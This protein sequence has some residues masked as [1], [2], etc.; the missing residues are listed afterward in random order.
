MFQDVSLLSSKYSCAGLEMRAARVVVHIVILISKIATTMKTQANNNKYTG[1]HTQTGMCEH[2]TTK[3]VW[4]VSAREKNQ[5]ERER[6]GTSALYLSTWQV[7]NICILN[8][9]VNFSMPGSRSR[10]S[11][12]KGEGE[13]AE[14][15]NDSARIQAQVKKSRL[16]VC[17]AKDA[18]TEKLLEKCWTKQSEQV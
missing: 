12:G 7:G 8:C 17:N 5:R 2:R 15:N 1:T 13:E 10:A 14:E 6:A 4:C 11:V 18:A 3:R 16:S 9:I